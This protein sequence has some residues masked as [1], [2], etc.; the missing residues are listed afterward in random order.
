MFEA[1]K[2]H[3]KVLLLQEDSVT[4]GFMGEVAAAIGEH[5]FEYLDGPVVRVGAM[6][7]PIPFAPALEAGYL[8]ETRLLEALQKIAGL[9]I[10]AFFEILLFK[11][12]HTIYNG[13]NKQ[14]YS[15]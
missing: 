13:N 3:N 11:F 7:T 8:P 12:L 9:L 6:D 5:C 10:I 4:G 2:T 15:S 1:V 14:Y